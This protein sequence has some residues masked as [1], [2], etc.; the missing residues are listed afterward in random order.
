[1]IVPVGGN[2][3][4]RDGYTRARP[5][6]WPMGTVDTRLT[7]ALVTP[8]F[9]V[10]NRGTSDEGH[11]N[12]AATSM[13]EPMRTLVANGTH[14]ALIEPPAFVVKNY[15]GVDSSLRC[16]VKSPADPL[17]AVTAQDHKRQQVRQYG[18]AVTPPVMAMILAR[19]I[20]SL[21]P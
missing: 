3:F 20:K 1:V 16:M 13:E 9:M 14:H 12:G 10:T 6:G 19:A 4:E 5:V 7:Q 11:L 15:G 8:P 2:R 18:N 21:A 17:G